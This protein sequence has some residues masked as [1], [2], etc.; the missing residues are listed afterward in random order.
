MPEKTHFVT[1][2]SGY[3][4]V[5]EPHRKKDGTMWHPHRFKFSDAHSEQRARKQAH[6]QNAAIHIRRM[7]S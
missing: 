3:I 4:T 6:A 2:R 7:K 5:G 1:R